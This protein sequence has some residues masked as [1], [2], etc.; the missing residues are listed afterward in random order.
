MTFD[1]TTIGSATV[2]YF[3]DTD[4]ELI[5]I[6]TRTSHEELLAFPLGA[7]I[8]INEFNMTTGGGGT[9]TAVA[10][11]RLGNRTAY[12][13][14]IGEDIAGEFVLKRLAEEH[15]TF[16]GSRAGQTGSSIILNSLR[17]DRT[18]LAFKGINNFIAPEDIPDID[19]AW[20]YLS[21][22]LGQSWDSMVQVLGAR[23]DRKA[24][25]LAFNPSS[26]QAEQGYENLRV[27]TDKVAILVMNREEACK[28][29]GEDTHTTGDCAGL[30]RA[31]AKVP[32]QVSAVT[33]GARGAW[34]WDGTRCCH[35][36]PAGNLHI[37]ETTGAGDAFA[38]T[39]TACRMRDMPLEDCVHYA[40]TNAESVLQYKGAKER[41]LSWEQLE[42]GARATSRHIDT[43]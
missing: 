40:M 16:I 36:E 12:F 43:F 15:I 3:A 6:D 25:Q 11:A 33:D 4:S 32:G 37:Q 27:L 22:M 13:G 19:S 23:L 17:D 18:I 7:K 35:G 30:A 28:Y 20:V 29:L 31:L 26:Y 21:S 42:S 38:A 5:R 2:D 8:L 41:L 24:F 34:V 39:F 1:I 14:K 10:F 9:N